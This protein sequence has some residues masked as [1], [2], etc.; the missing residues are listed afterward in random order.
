MT[1]IELNMQ[2][3][4]SMQY[5]ADHSLQVN[6]TAEATRRSKTEQHARQ[7]LLALGKKRSLPKMEMAAIATVQ[8]AAHMVVSGGSES[9]NG[10]IETFR[11]WLQKMV[12]FAL[13]QQVASI[14]THA[15][16]CMCIHSFGLVL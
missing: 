12:Y 16:K 4:A 13:L 10:H 1:L 2:S 9:A 14:P 6:I 5:G 3:C 11:R 7:S 8:A 15:H